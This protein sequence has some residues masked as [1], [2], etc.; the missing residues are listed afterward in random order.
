MVVINEK[1]P[2]GRPPDLRGGHYYLLQDTLYRAVAFTNSSGNI[3]EAVTNDTRKG[4]AATAEA[5]GESTSRNLAITR[6][7]S[8]G[9]AI[10]SCHLNMINPL[11][12]GHFGHPIGMVGVLARIQDA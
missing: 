5:I 2:P 7:G 1:F 8:R 11:K 4:V 6:T 3:V 10:A 12:N 9:R